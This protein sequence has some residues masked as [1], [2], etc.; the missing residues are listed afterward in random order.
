[1]A[2]KSILKACGLDD[3]HINMLTNVFGVRDIRSLAY[4]LSEM[5]RCSPHLDNAKIGIT[6]G[7]IELSPLELKRLVAC[8]FLFYEYIAQ[9]GEK[10]FVY[11]KESTGLFADYHGLDEDE[12]SQSF[13]EKLDSK[14]ESAILWTPEGDAGCDKEKGAVCLKAIHGLR[15]HSTYTDVMETRFL[16][17]QFESTL[18]EVMHKFWT[19][20]PDNRKLSAD[21]KRDREQVYAN[22]KLNEYI[23]YW[24]DL[25]EKPKKAP[26]QYKKEG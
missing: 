6:I 22:T 5:L 24:L 23:R 12:V 17:E 8:F 25:D 16:A 19:N 10:A 9:R 3:K 11:N 2:M 20:V 1:M 26:K 21:T 7:D 14:I 15:D 18:G 4:F 13:Q